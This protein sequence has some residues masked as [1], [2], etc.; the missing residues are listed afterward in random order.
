MTELRTQWW[1]QQKKLHRG[2]PTLHC[3]RQPPP[4]QEVAPFQGQFL[5]S[6]SNVPQTLRTDTGQTSG[7]EPFFAGDVVVSNDDVIFSSYPYALQRKPDVLAKRLSALGV[8]TDPMGSYIAPDRAAQQKGVD[9]ATV[10]ASI[11]DRL[12]ARAVVKEPNLFIF[13]GIPMH[14]PDTS[15]WPLRVNQPLRFRDDEIDDKAVAVQRNARVDGVFPT[16]N[17]MGNVVLTSISE[18]PL[19]RPP[20]VTDIKEILAVGADVVAILFEASSS[21]YLFS[22]SHRRIFRE[23][24]AAALVRAMFCISLADGTCFLATIDGYELRIF[25]TRYDSPF[26][27]L[28]LSH[29]TKQDMYG[30]SGSNLVA[31]LDD[32]QHLVVVSSLTLI[33]KV[34][35]LNSRKNFKVFEPPAAEAP[36]TTSAVLSR[37]ES[38]SAS[39]VAAGGVVA[40]MASATSQTPVTSVLCQSDDTQTTA[41]VAATAADLELSMDSETK[42]RQQL[43]SFVAPELAIMFDG[44]DIASSVCSLDDIVGFAVLYKVCLLVPSCFCWLKLHG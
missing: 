31:M 6:S 3:A 41:S 21:V 24:R 17:A 38:A 9:V 27:T 4:S 25:D 15:Q 43:T 20:A 37:T 13:E 36:V 34:Y 28:L 29:K 23:L 35:V 40:A 14:N 1:Q 8:A 18:R 7:F 44:D 19:I 12:E 26:N 30:V 42:L 39:E 11:H 5:F 10:V 2:L 22:R 16:I 32:G 33:I